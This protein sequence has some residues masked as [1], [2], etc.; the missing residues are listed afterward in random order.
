MT[1]HLLADDDLSP[2]EQTDGPRPGRPAARP[3]PTR[4][5]LAGPRSVAV[6]FDK[7]TLRTQTSF[8]AGIAELGGS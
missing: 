1:R 3:T 2:A 4:R 6:I 7:P 8:S 5:P